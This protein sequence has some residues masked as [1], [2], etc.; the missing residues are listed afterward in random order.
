MNI[1]IQ[2]KKINK[3]RVIL[4]KKLGSQVLIGQVKKKV[5]LQVVRELI[6]LQKVKS[7]FLYFCLVSS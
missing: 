7:S 6:I 3:K 1:G 2:E 4:D 5:T